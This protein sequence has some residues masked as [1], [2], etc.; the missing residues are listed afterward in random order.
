[1]IANTKKGEL[2]VKDIKC[3]TVLSLDL[4]GKYN[5][6]ILKS[7]NKPY[8]RESFLDSV[9]NG[10]SIIRTFRKFAGRPLSEVFRIKAAKLK[11]QILRTLNIRN[12]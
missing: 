8:N 11:S 6:A 5:P 10:K 12:K 9:A 2:A 7:P 3:D 4:V 1:M